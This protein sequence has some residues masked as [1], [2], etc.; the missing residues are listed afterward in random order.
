M[1]M[2]ILSDM[3][4]RATPSQPLDESLMTSL[5]SAPLIAEE[6]AFQ[7]AYLKNKGNGKV[8]NTTNEQD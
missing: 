8:A 7:K 4:S 6:L 3:D 1:L 2:E 5:I